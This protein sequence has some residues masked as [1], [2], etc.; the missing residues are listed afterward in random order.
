MPTYEERLT[1]FAQGKKLL[2]L[3]RPIRDRADAS[4][5]A[6]G[7]VLPRTLYAL[8]DLD[9]GRH[10]FVGDTC[11][12][13]LVKLGVVLRRFAKESG[14]AAYEP[15]MQLRG[16][17]TAGPEQ[18][19]RP[20]NGPSTVSS[21]AQTNFPI[22]FIIQNPENYRAWVS[23][24]SPQ[25]GTRSWGYAEEGRWEETWR[26]GGE[27]GLVLEKVQGERPEAASQCLT[28][29]WQEAC[30]PFNGPESMDPL[31]S[32]TNGDNQAQGLPDTLLALVD[33][34]ARAYGGNHPVAVSRIVQPGASG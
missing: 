30:L 13:E 14:Q 2:R 29:A 11:L 10:F 27:R 31:A 26:R 34:V 25:G 23:V 7:S 17:E 12:R 4:C 33:Q 32:R 9:F 22:V 6:C 8:K 20:A 28:R 15:E 19:L 16:E 21:G 5:D 3:P 18:D 1:S 24:F